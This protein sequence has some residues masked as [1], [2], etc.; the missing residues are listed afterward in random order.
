M[1]IRASRGRA[2]GRS[3]SPGHRRAA[4]RV[5]HRVVDRR[6]SAPSSRSLFGVLWAR[7]SPA[8]GG[9][10][11]AGEVEP[12]RRAEP[13]APSPQ[14]PA[15]EASRPAPHEAE[16]YSREK[17]LEVDDAR[18]RRRD[19]R[20]S[21]TVPVLGF[22]VLPVV[23]RPGPRGPRPRPARSLPRG[24]VADRDVPDASPRRATSRGSPSFVR[25]NGLLERPAELH[26]PL[27][28]LRAPRLPGAAERADPEDEKTEY[29]D[30]TLIPTAAVGLRLPVPRRRSTTTR[31]TAPPARP[32][33]RSTATRSRSATATSSSATPFSVSNV[34]GTGA[35]GEDLQ[36]ATTR[37]RASTST[38]SSPGSTRSSR[39]ADGGAA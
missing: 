26:D 18:P 12:E 22:T 37:S 21:I 8:R 31:G 34:E 5:R 20:R 11:E 13:V 28:P 23:P 9:L 24:R 2:C 36:V 1:N 10:A 3:A 14:P 25:Y 16:S 35:D 4:R 39:P 33:A 27:E 6:R 30:V 17:F 19:R 32:C 7:D 29:R 15:A 38:G